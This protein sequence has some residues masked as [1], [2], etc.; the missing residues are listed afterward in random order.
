MKIHSFIAAGAAAILAASCIT[1]AE[2]VITGKFGE[3]VPEKVHIK[4]V[5]IDT[6]VTVENGTFTFSLPTNRYEEVRVSYGVRGPRVWLI[7][8][9]TS[10]TADFSEETPRAISS[11][12]NSLTSKLNEVLDFA[13]SFYEVNGEKLE[14]MENA[15][16]TEEEQ[17]AFIDSVDVVFIDYSKNLIRKNKDNYLGIYGLRNLYDECDAEEVLELI[18]IMSEKAQG[19]E[20]VQNIK[21]FV[22]ALDNTSEGRMFTDFTVNSIVGM[23]RSIP[24]QYKYGEVKLSDYVGKGK[25]IL[26]DFWASWCGPCMREVPNIKSV[27]D[28]YH[29]E[30]FDVLSIAVWDRAEASVKAAESKEMNW[31]HIVNAESIPT[32]LYGI[33]GIPHIILFGPDG[34][35]LKRGLRGEAIG[36]E[37][38]KYLGE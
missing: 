29:G 3:E 32:D 27:Y 14:E 9:G 11:R 17:Q 8:D 25:Y 5:G 21:N 18:G 2:T 34:T 13:S 6:T 31:N 36:Q 37:V 10:L 15:G 4:T 1:P 7:A 23:T 24:P 38:A 20:T 16:A 35:I 22:I 12:S 28:K 33:E 30:N 26:V 19:T